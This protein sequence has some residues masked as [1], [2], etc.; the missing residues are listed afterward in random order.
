[1]NL[2]RGI[3]STEIG[4]TQVRANCQR[5]LVLSGSRNQ[6][7]IPS[8][9]HTHGEGA[10]DELALA[11]GTAHSASTDVSDDFTRAPLGKSRPEQTGSLERTRAWG[12]G[13]HFR[14]RDPRA[15]SDVE[16]A[17]PCCPFYFMIPFLLRSLLLSLLL[18]FVL[19]FLFQRILFLF[20]M[21][22]FSLLCPFP[23]FLLT[24]SPFPSHAG[25]LEHRSAGTERIDP[26]PDHN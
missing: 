7:T 3:L 1:M 5:A 23:L 15:S 2:S 26:P 4:R 22:M 24:F 14:S 10:S 12:G 16:G 19:A 8:S 17:L 13:G 18:C 20:F 25:R 6:R 21:F 9:T 11:G